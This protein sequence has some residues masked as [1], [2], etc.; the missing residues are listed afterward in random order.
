MS[1]PE[2]RIVNDYQTL[3]LIQDGAMVFSQIEDLSMEPTYRAIL[4]DDRIAHFMSIRTGQIVSENPGLMVI[5]NSFLDL[6][7]M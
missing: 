5:F 4:I 7:G 6:L 3:Q 1:Q 2:I